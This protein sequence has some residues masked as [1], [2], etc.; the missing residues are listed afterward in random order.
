M[1][2]SS[3]DARNGPIPQHRSRTGYP[4]DAMM[5]VRLMRIRGFTVKHG[6]FESFS[7]TGIC[8]PC[9]SSRLQVLLLHVCAIAVVALAA[10]SCG[11][12]AGSNQERSISVDQE[13]SFPE[14]QIVPR[15]VARG[16][17]GA[18][19]VAGSANGA[20]RAM[21]TN[22]HELLW[23]YID[24][25]QSSGGSTGSSSLQSEFKSAVSLNNGNFLF[26]GSSGGGKSSLVT[27]LDAKGGLV[28]RRIGSVPNDDPIYTSAGYFHCL[29]WNEGI[30]V[31]GLAFNG[32]RGV[33]WL[34][35]LDGNGV[36]EWETLLPD[37]PVP[38]AIQTADH[39]LVLST[40]RSASSESIFAIVNEKG[41]IVAKR[42]MRNAGFLQLRDIV[43][44]NTISV[45]SYGDGGS[46]RY[47][48]NTS[49]EDL[50][51][52]Q[53]ISNFVAEE[54]CGYV[55]PDNSL[56]L[57]GRA[58]Q[59]A[60]TWMSKTGRVL[61]TREFSPRY[62]AF[63]LDDAVPISANQFMTVRNSTSPHI[64]DQGLVMSWVTFH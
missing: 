51:E 59:A 30:A 11:K 19:V 56:V 14:F 23:T 54:G 21:A 62:P 52:P 49:L 64:N 32:T 26:C 25:S 18:F 29:R 46:T 58:N 9:F 61:A 33:S 43:P 12:K 60:V 10:T 41:T 3:R 13:V 35:K 28:E 57:F 44:S 22:G 8:L 15:V 63:V 5:A 4:V 50:K 37:M 6:S 53:S 38:Q 27:I 34:V 16:G 31:T 17:G 20:A 2:C 7:A 55:N 39:N 45:I 42:S 40:Y 24:G 1:I 36:K 47:T 48:L